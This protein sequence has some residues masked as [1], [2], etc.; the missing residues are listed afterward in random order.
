MSEC[1]C[2]KKEIKALYKIV[3]TLSGD[4]IPEVAMYICKTCKKVVEEL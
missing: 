4:Y 2:I 3:R 1:N